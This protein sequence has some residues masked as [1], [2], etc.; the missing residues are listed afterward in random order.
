MPPGLLDS[1]DKPGGSRAVPAGNE[2]VF[3]VGER[4]ISQGCRAFQD[5]VCQ[6][7]VDLLRRKN[8]EHEIRHEVLKLDERRIEPGG[9]EADEACVM[10]VGQHLRCR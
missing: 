6:V 1:L 4:I 3:K 8:E 2:P 10:E 5:L 9:V 7:N